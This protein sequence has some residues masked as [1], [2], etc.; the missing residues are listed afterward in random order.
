[1]PYANITVLLIDDN[2]QVRQT[3]RH[4]LESWKL[5][6]IE[7][8]DGKIGLALFC[9]HKPEFVITDIVMPEMD[10]IETIRKMRAIDPQAKI[11][12]MSGGGDDK[13]PDPLALATELGAIAVLEKPF[14]RLQLRAAVDEVLGGNVSN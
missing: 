9:S 4:I 8:A 1:M 14:R 12:A 2:S 6:V 10:G 11:I 13:Y 5:N 7:A 3:V